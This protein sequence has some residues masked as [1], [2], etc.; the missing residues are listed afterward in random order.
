MVIGGMA[1]GKRSPEQIELDRARIARWWVEKVSQVEM[2]KRLG[3]S[4][5]MVSKELRK[6]RRQWQETTQA[7]VAEVMAETLLTLDHVQRQ[8][9]VGWRKSRRT[10]ERQT[11]RKREKPGNLPAGAAGTA[12]PPN[13]ELEATLTKES[14]AGDPR[15]LQVILGVR[16][17]ISKLRGLYP[18]TGPDGAPPA[19]AQ[20]QVV[21]VL[22]DNGRGDGP[23]AITVAE[24]RARGIEPP[25]HG[26]E[27][28]TAAGSADAV[29]D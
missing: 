5:P 7:D 6:L 29:R 4:Q 12:P 26:D 19:A 16:D 1:G 28:G 11:S 15:F 17:Q 25:E 8:A 3:V 2:A 24:A 10:A 20:A 22:P 14:Q 13:V 9:W 27:P 18:P 21:I 23:P